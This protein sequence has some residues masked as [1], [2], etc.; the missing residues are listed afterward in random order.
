MKHLTVIAFILLAFFGHT[1]KNTFTKINKRETW[2]KI[3]GTKNADQLSYKFKYARILSLDF[4][5]EYQSFING[6]KKSVKPNENEL[7]AILDLTKKEL[8]PQTIQELNDIKASSK[9]KAIKAIVEYFVFK[10]NIEFGDIKECEKQKSVIVSNLKNY[11]GIPFENIYNEFAFRYY[12]SG[13][14]A[15]CIEN[16]R[17]YSNYIDTRDIV[18]LSGTLMN[19]G[20]LYHKMTNEK[21]A[22]EYFNK[23]DKINKNTD[24]KVKGMIYENLGISYINLSQPEKAIDYYN[25][26]SKL[27]LSIKDTL[28]Y[29]SLILNISGVYIT[30][31]LYEKAIKNLKESIHFLERTKNTTLA[32]SAYSQLGELFSDLKDTTSAIS[33]YN[34]AIQLGKKHNYFSYLYAQLGKSK[35]LPYESSNK[36]LFELLNE[37]QERGN[38]EKVN[39][40]YNQIGNNYQR[41]GKT[42]EAEKYYRM[43]LEHALKKTPPDYEEIYGYHQNLGVIYFDLKKYNK[44]LEYYKKA[45]Q[46]KD[47]RSLSPE[48][49]KN[50]YLL[51]AN[52]YGKLKDYKNAYINLSTYQ[53]Y[54]DSLYNSSINEQILKIKQ[55]FQTQQIQDSLNLNKK[56]LNLYQVKIEKQKAA[57]QRN[58]AIIIGLLIL[59]ILTIG[60][61]LL[62]VKNNRQ[63]KK[64][65]E[66]LIEKNEEIKLQKDLVEQK[67]EEI[68]D[69]I[70]Y[71][72]RLQDTILPPKVR[73]DELFSNNFVLFK[74]KDIVSGDFYVCE[75]LESNG[76]KIVMVAVAD[77]TGHGVPG[78]LVSMVCSSALKKT[79]LELG[80]T[81]PGKILDKT[82]ELVIEAFHI[83]NEKVRDGM[84]ISLACINFTTK[85]LYWSGANNPLWRIKNNEIT[86]F[87]ANKQAISQQEQITPFTTHTIEFQEG[88]KFYFISDGFADQFGGDNGKKL[89]TKNFKELLLS[90]CNLS[91]ENQGVEIENF[92]NTWKLNVEQV[93][94]VCVFGIEMN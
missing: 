28:R 93:D 12:Y 16:F 48:N 51:Y 6:L 3:K 4:P 77:C 44:A 52:V 38:L 22:I 43:A 94:D 78:A 54:T 82:T 72:K 11:P 8:T 49:L 9:D 30:E 55:E 26:A 2:E 76:H 21:K 62:V 67:N 46:Y 19:I 29:S 37:L 25:K 84:D 64:T 65:N 60:I 23:A 27:Y 61:V 24:I 83:A 5:K 79:V 39:V 80:V 57:N 87:K 47:W 31:K 7:A 92:F 13:N 56:E 91:M 1:Q 69:S 14:I 85:T 70:N 50:R 18:V 71:A 89:K 73:I 68:I 53:I 63:R 42:N 88:D 17:K 15:K 90:T 41:L 34:K 45:E 86:E 81:D 35:V 20:V 10:Y 74:P 58:F 33:S 40:I 59:T 36:L 75:S 66:F 32:A